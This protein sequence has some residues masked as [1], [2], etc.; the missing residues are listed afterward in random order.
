MLV[1]SFTCLS[2]WLVLDS[3]PWFSALVTAGRAQ[4]T[5]ISSSHLC[6]VEAQVW[7]SLELLLQSILPSSS[8]WCELRAAGLFICARCPKA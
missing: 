3:S 8:A 7:L 2:A 5:P 4:R 6:G 1:S